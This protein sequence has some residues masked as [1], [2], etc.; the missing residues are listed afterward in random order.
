MHTKL[1]S[2]EPSVYNPSIENS[3]IATGHDA[4]CFPFI[5]LVIVPFPHSRFPPPYSSRPSIR[6][7]I[8][9]L[10]MSSGRLGLGLVLLGQLG[11][12]VSVELVIDGLALRLRLVRG[13]VSVGLGVLDV[14]SNVR[15]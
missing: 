2:C 6:S 12:V 9:I 8:H 5:R 13:G 7:G 11:G 15:V 3:R 14:L 4:G 1:G 10:T